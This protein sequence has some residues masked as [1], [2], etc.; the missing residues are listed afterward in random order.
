MTVADEDG[1]LPDCILV[2]A[3][4]E[5]LGF[6]LEPAVAFAFALVPASSAHHSALSISDATHD[7]A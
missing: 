6:T 5:V 2:A 1:A 4:E 7:F 3:V